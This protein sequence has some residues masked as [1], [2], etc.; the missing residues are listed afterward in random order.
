MRLDLL[1]PIHKYIHAREILRY[2]ITVFNN[3]K[4]ISIY[5]F[6]STRMLEDILHLTALYKGS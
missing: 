4:A 6:K 1:A 5:T 3:D 2:H